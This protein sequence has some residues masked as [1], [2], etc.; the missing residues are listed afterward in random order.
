[1]DCRFKVQWQA[2]KTKKPYGCSLALALTLTL[3]FTLIHTL[4][5]YTNYVIW[6]LKTSLLDPV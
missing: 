1:M 4:I 3:A 2:I 5:T 6:R